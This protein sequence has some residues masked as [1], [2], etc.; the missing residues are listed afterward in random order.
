M[1]HQFDTLSVHAG[2]VPDATGA[3]MPPIYTSSTYAQRAP[4]EHSGYE[5]ARSGNPTRGA[6]EKALAELEGGSAGF[7]FASGLAA[8]STVLEL[9]DAGSE[10]VALDDLYGGAWR[11]F[12]G[13]RKRT[14]G[15]KTRYVA[16]D[17]L[18]ALREAV[19]PATRLVWLELPTNPLLKVADLA[20][21]V[22]V[23][24][25]VSAL[26]VVDAT[27][28]TPYLLRPLDYGVD[29]VIHSVTK[30]LNGHSDVIGGAA[31]V[32]TPELAERLGYLQNA[33]GGVLDPFSSFLAMRGLRTLAL[34][35]Q[36]HSSNAQSVA[37]W[38]AAQGGVEY[39]A[40]PGLPSH[41]QHALAKR[42]FPRGFGGV[43]SVWL[44][45][46]DA[47]VRR[48]I[49]ALKVFTLAESLGGVESL[50]NL[51]WAMTHASIPEPDRIRRGITPKLLRLS[52][53]VEHIDD[54]IADL[55]A[56]FAA[57]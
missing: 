41:P 17:D 56:G 44:K 22:K 37:E 52:V 20:A 55:R 27:F 29:I 40:Y 24:H 53:G 21:V 43:V 31:I 14:A 28:A 4:G 47:G 8:M 3:V 45:A 5:Y 46:D 35:M 42:Q 54:L 48:F 34:R 12:E 7:A 39:V 50:L 25:A 38:L 30:Y 10:I 18:N 57:V 6:F 19:T 49:A 26:V 16:P 13:V 36:R 1:S 32:R 33:V 11:L 15:L 51:P 23:A 9:L 2:Y